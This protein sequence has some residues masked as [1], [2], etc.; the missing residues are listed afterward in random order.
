[1]TEPTRYGADSTTPMP[2]LASDWGAFSV[3]TKRCTLLTLSPAMRT[4]TRRTR[5]MGYCLATM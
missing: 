1:M 2:L 3:S 5:S 4:I